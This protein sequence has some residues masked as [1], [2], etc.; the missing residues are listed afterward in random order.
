MYHCRRSGLLVAVCAAIFKVKTCVTGCD[1]TGTPHSQAIARS[2]KPGDARVDRIGRV[3]ERATRGAETL[4]G[5]RVADRI[6]VGRG[7]GSAVAHADVR[8]VGGDAGGR[9]RRQRDRD[10]VVARERR[11]DRV[12]R[13]LGS[14]IA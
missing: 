8:R 2:R 3:V 5:R 1:F 7:G 14:G 12:E 13:D 4:R 10:V 6:A 11:R 9:R